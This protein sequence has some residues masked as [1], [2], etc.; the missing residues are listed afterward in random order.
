MQVA[1]KARDIV[2]FTIVIIAVFLGCA[3][4]WEPRWLIDWLD[5]RDG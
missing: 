4:D 2:L 1:C 3:C 5:C